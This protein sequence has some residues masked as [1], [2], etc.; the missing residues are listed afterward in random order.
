MDLA[1]GTTGR[2][3]PSDTVHRRVVRVGSLS[4]PRAWL[5]A[6]V[7]AAS[8]AATGI[9][10]VEYVV[11]VSRDEVLSNVRGYLVA[12]ARAAARLID[13]DQHALL[14]RPEQEA[15]AAYD[16]ARAPLV[17]L[18]ASNPDLRFAFTGRVIGDSMEFVADGAPRAARSGTG[19]ASDRA[20][21]GERA[22]LSPGEPIVWRT[23]RPYV[24]P[25]PTTNEW[26]PG[27]R[28][29]APILARDGRMTGY[30]GLTMSAARYTR[31]VALTNRA[32]RG[33]EFGTL[34]LAIL[35]GALAFRVE[36][37][38]EEVVTTLDTQRR[39]AQAAVSARAAFMAN[40]SHEIRTP[41]HGV[42]GMSE[43]M[44]TRQL[45]DEAQHAISVIRRS[46]MALRALLDS[47]LDNAK[48]E[49]GQMTVESVPVNLD[50]LAED[51]AALFAG[52]AS[53]KGVTLDLRIPRRLDV[54]V[55]SDATRLRQI[56]SNL[57]GNAVKF[58]E[59]GH[60]VLELES[61]V[62]PEERADIRVRVSDS[63]IGISADKMRRLFDA[64][65][66]G[67]PTIARRFGGTGLGLAICR[68]LVEL[69]GGTI[70]AESKP[71]EG[72]TFEVRLSLTTVTRASLT[73]DESANTLPSSL[74]VLVVDDVEMNRMVA[75][76][77]L[78]KL[79][80]SVQT[81]SSGQEALDACAAE[82]FD[83]VL[84]DLH[85]PEMDGME[86]ARRLRARH[87]PAERRMPIVALSASAMREDRDGAIAAGMDDFASKPIDLDS[88]RR[89][90]QRWTGTPARGV[91]AVR[92]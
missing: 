62:G 67:D 85:M 65:A 37:R 3:E 10:V 57:L 56:L 42:L 63:G 2:G 86:T 21:I 43:A 82:A 77:M 49:A 76:A 74:R 61:A 32:A 14:V 12:S 29:F 88:L 25:A 58:T 24:E 28:A 45:D 50:Q 16:A 1:A 73:A 69:L 15:T 36:M 81:A 52:S 68:Q 44:L 19:N 60:V 31:F 51:V 75:R 47:V 53:Q 23:Q 91:P 27:I 34:V 33:A 20:P 84:L 39:E 35:F 87:N 71:G 4:V 11:R 13:G 78:A 5:L 72:T 7:A 38:H 22:A 17:A 92:I 54:D 66:Q 6:A 70:S 59:H 55:I 41:L 30:V 83:L 64:F 79:G 80:V 89:V 8:I 26:G 46:A 40:V 90:L 18:L 9:G 48:L